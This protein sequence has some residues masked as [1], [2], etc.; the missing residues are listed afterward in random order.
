M[1][2][3]QTEDQQENEDL[4]T[5]LMEFYEAQEED[6]ITVSISELYEGFQLWKMLNPKEK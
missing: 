5:F 4:K 1:K 6:N 3:Q 2:D